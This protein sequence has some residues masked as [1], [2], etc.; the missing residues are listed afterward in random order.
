MVSY[1]LVAVLGQLSRAVYHAQPAYKKFWMLIPL[2]IKL[3]ECLGVSIL[4]F[5]IILVQ[6]CSFLFRMVSYALVAMLV[7]KLSRAV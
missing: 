1:S 3:S 6:L 7:G 4:K 5:N 2:I